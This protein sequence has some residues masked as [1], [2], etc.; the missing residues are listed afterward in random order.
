MKEQNLDDWKVLSSLT[1]KRIR[2]LHF[3]DKPVQ[4]LNMLSDTHN[5]TIDTDIEVEKAM[6]DVNFWGVLAVTQA[7]APRLIAAK[8]SIA[9]IS[10]I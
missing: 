8:G 10:P 9:N 6:Y 5:W 4:N 3:R 2:S 7:F 1:G